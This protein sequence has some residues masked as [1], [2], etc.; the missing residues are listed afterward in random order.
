MCCVNSKY[1][2]IMPGGREGESLEG[3]EGGREEPE[4]YGELVSERVG[5]YAVA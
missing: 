3:R 4:I 2:L 1:Q 5:N